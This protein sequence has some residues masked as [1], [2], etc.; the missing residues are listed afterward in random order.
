LETGRLAARRVGRGEA[1]ASTRGAAAQAAAEGAA[2]G[3]T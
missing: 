1:S 2:A 3:V